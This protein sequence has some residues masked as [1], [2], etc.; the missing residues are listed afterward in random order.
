M[1]AQNTGSAALTDLQFVDARHGWVRNG[2]QVR[3]TVDGGQTWH[4]LPSPPMPPAPHPDAPP[5][6]TDFTQLLFVD[7]TRGWAA[8]SSHFTRPEGLTT[9]QGWHTPPTAAAV[10]GR[11]SPRRWIA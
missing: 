3:G 5:T 11:W 7:A 8:V 2:E 1:G 9:T 4:E 10:G 6:H